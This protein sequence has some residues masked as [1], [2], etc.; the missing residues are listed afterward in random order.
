M[1]RTTTF[2][3]VLFLLIGI[4]GDGTVAAPPGEVPGDAEFLGDG[5]T[6]SWSSVAAATSY[7]VYRG[8][9]F[10]LTD[11]ACRVTG[12]GS[13]TALL[14]EVPQLPGEVFYFLIGAEN[15]DGVGTVGAASDGSPRDIE[16]PCSDA[17]GDLVS[18]NL[19]N[20]LGVSNTDQYDTDKDGSG[21]ACDPQTAIFESMTVSFPTTVRDLVVEGGATLT[22]DAKITATGNA[23]I[24]SGGVV[25]HSLRRLEGLELEV[26][27]SLD[28]EA[29]AVID[30]DGRG[31]RGGG[32]NTDVTSGETYDENDQ[33]VAGATFFTLTGLSMGAGASYGGNG[34]EG[35]FA[36]TYFADPNEPYGHLEDPRHL[37]SGGGGNDRA[38]GGDGGGRARIT[39]ASFLVDGVVTASGEDGRSYVGT[40]YSRLSGG[41]SGGSITISVGSLS[42][43]GEIRANGGRGVS[44]NSGA[45]GGGR[46]AIFH[47][48]MSLQDSSI[49]ACGGSG[50]GVPA[51][52]GT[53]YLQNNADS[54]GHLIVDNGGASNRYATYLLTDLTTFRNL[55]VRNLARVEVRTQDLPS[56]TVS[57]LVLLSNNGELVLQDGV[58]MAVSNSAGFDLELE[59]GATLSLETGSVLAADTLRINGGTLRPEIDLSYAGA[60]EFQITG[61]G[62]LEIL[63][64]T[65][66]SLGVFDPTNIL[67]GTVHIADAGRLDIS[68]NQATIGPEAILMKDGALGPADQ[69]AHL[70]IESG[71]VLTHS[72][73][74]VGGLVLNVSGAL[75]VH[76]GGRIDLEEKG[77]LGGGAGSAF[78]TAGETFDSNDLIAAGAEGM[79]F[80]GGVGGGAGASHGGQGAHG[81]RL[82]H[83]FEPDVPYGHVESP[84]HLGSGG[85]G[86]GGVGPGGNGGG[87]VL[88]V[89]ADM[90]LDGILSVDGGAGTNHSGGGS[91]GSITVQVGSLGGSGQIR[92]TGG[93]GGYGRDLG[94]AGGGGRIAISYDTMTLAQSNILVHGGDTGRLASAGTVYLVDDAEAYGDLIVDNANVDST[95]TTPLRTTLGTFRDWTVRQSGRLEVAPSMTPHVYVRDLLIDG[96]S[97]RVLHTLRSFSGL[98]ISV[99]G[100]LTLANGS[101]ITA[102]AMG[103]LGGGDVANIFGDAGETFDID[104]VTVVA[105]CTSGSGA[106]HGGLGGGPSPNV[107]YGIPD[108]PAHLGSGGSRAG[109]GRG[110]GGGGRIRID[111]SSC[112][113]TAGTAIT[114][115]GGDAVG[116]SGIQGG[117]SGGSIELHCVQISGTGRLAANGGQGAGT[118]GHGGG[119]GRVAL[120]TSESIVNI[121]LEA[122]GGAS[123]GFGDAGQS[124]TTFL[125]P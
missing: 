61:G 6:L 50:P 71:G 52:A 5:Q 60:S 3:S 16:A 17:D 92:A 121:V 122:L 105:G 2:P 14:H 47:N 65:T 51:S 118:D 30:L 110:G 81:T 107:T 82:G 59:T 26:Q 33:I 34:A 125:G 112:D 72:P 69:L 23:T 123:T 78:G 55:S 25:T 90:V 27:G 74:F 93:G 37:G 102:D 86:F 28:L 62:R 79:G 15:T 40:T 100:A 84:G 64:G 46:I 36:G 115:N 68:T 53:I 113:L 10:A 94:G 83:V 98:R 31:L 88:I 109:S 19:D 38:P 35:Q 116:S 18:D 41:G 77:L 99:S 48:T 97:S 85:G 7:N 21:D 80:G 42:G 67:S 103:L 45:G 89:A 58:T 66:F 43:T 12:T 124:G 75:D 120:H 9:D 8:S 101:G 119:G 44:L 22:A 73:R 54:H 32:W 20:C 70:T 111:A 13:L 104:G 39:A 56:F 57:D 76:A 96:G 4:C 91:G 24:Q 29:G 63:A 114:A 11:H 108:Q 117:G 87:R 1:S 106:S 49:A 95:L